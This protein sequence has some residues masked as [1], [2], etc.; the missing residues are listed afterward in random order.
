MTVGSLGTTFRFLKAGPDGSP[1][2]PHLGGR[3]TEDCTLK[4]SLGYIDMSQKQTKPGTGPSTCNPRAG[5]A[6]PRGLL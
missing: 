3:G 4:A 1:I 5:E 2:T 6:E